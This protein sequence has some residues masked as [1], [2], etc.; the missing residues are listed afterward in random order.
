MLGLS[1][2]ENKRRS[3]LLLLASMEGVG[4]AKGDAGTGKWRLG[5]HHGG[6]GVSH[7][8]KGRAQGARCRPDD[9]NE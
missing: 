3:G 1:S 6:R 8:R 9:E 5:E 7:G 4:A 2:M